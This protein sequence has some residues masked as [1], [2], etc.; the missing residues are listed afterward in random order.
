MLYSV[1]SKLLSLYYEV[2]RSVFLLTVAIVIMFI[3]LT[4]EISF[5]ATKNLLEGDL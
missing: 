5:L 1:A 3:Y 2:A 4:L